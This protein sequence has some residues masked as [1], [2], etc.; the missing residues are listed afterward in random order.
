MAVAPAPATTNTVTI[1]PI[2]LTVPSAAPVPEK[3]AA[4]NS[5]SRMLKMNVNNTVYGIVNIS[6][7]TI[8][9]RATNQA[10]KMNSRHANGGLNICTK[11]S[12]AIAKKPPKARTGLAMTLEATITGS[13]LACSSSPSAA[14]PSDEQPVHAR[15]L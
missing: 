1:G 6:V 8:D 12:S 9:T 5:V 7:G 3:S 2:W 4:P 14:D 15:R 13:F 11:V 10:C